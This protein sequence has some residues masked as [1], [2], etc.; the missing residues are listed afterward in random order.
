MSLTQE[1]CT[2]S[3]MQYFNHILIIALKYGEKHIK[4]TSTQYLFYNKKLHKLSVMLGH[5]TILLKCFVNYMF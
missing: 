1:P 3:T 4:T 2:V 5:W